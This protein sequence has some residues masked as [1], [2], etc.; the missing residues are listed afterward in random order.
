MRFYKKFKFKQNPKSDKFIKIE[1]PYFYVDSDYIVGEFR[2]V[3]L[4]KILTGDE[5]DPI[6]YANTFLYL[7]PKLNENIYWTFYTKSSSNL[8]DFNLSFDDFTKLIKE[9][10]KLTYENCYTK[11]HKIIYNEEYIVKKYKIS[12]YSNTFKKDLKNILENQLNSWKI[13]ANKELLKDLFF[14]LIGN[15]N[16]SYESM[17]LQNGLKIEEVEKYLSMSGIYI[18]E[19]ELEYLNTKNKYDKKGKLVGILESEKKIIKRQ[20]YKDYII[21]KQIKYLLNNP[22]KL[23]TLDDIVEGCKYYSEYY[24]EMIFIDKEYIR[25]W[26]KK[27]KYYTKFIKYHVKQFN[28]KKKLIERQ[29]KIMYI[30][31]FINLKNNKEG[32]KMVSFGRND[33][34]KVVYYDFGD[35]FGE[36]YS[37]GNEINTY[38]Q[39]YDIDGEIESDDEFEL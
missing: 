31:Y 30:L 24:D 36:D 4:P 25:Q 22:N 12:F 21:E 32:K 18:R 7:N 34:G 1:I 28:K 39:K 17:A 6:R 15:I 13:E 20:S 16:L 35:E 27:D 10:E 8:S 9:K 14:Q 19:R 2:R 33:N 29:N 11:I 23:F 26:I 37:V 38:S 5:F 3:E